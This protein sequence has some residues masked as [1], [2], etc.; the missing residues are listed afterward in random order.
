MVK[1]LVEDLGGQRGEGDYMVISYLL[2]WKVFV[3]NRLVDTYRPA[4][5]QRTCK[6]L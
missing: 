4:Y 5:F 1:I 6:P 3:C 2:V